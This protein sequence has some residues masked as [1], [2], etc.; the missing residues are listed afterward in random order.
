MWC[1]LQSAAVT[2][3][4]PFVFQASS[5]NMHFISALSHTY[6]RHHGFH[7]IMQLAWYVAASALCQVHIPIWAQLW[8]PLTSVGDVWS[9]GS[10]IWEKAKCRHGVLWLLM[11]R[12]SNSC[13]VG[14][15]T[16]HLKISTP[17]LISQAPQ[18]MIPH[19]EV[20]ISHDHR[21]THMIA[22]CTLIVQSSF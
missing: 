15:Q 20:H 11:E 21:I 3:L 16:W 5:S 9:C 6:L 4:S 18:Y 13:M 7:G 14:V 2:P 1:R 8:V 10:A 17:N 12:S 22:F 19:P